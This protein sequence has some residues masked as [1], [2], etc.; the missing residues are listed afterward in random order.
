MTRATSTDPV[1]HHAQLYRWKKTKKNVTLWLSNRAGMAPRTDLGLNGKTPVYVMDNSGPHDRLQYLFARRLMKNGFTDS[2][3]FR[4][5]LKF[6]QSLT[7]HV[8]HRGL[9]IF[10]DSTTFDFL[11][12]CWINDDGG[13]TYNRTLVNQLHQSIRSRFQR[14]NEEGRRTVILGYT[15]GNS[16]H[17]RLVC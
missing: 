12:V 4:S 9:D 15:T 3:A 6:V 8:D 5:V 14:L 13:A 10:L 2:G 11:I 7:N 1:Q 17:V 16:G